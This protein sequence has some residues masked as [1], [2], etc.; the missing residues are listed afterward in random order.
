M[1]SIILA[2]V[3]AAPVSAVAATP[4]Y[5]NPLSTMHH[6]RQ[7]MVYLTF[8]NNT[9]QDR[10][11]RI[12]NNQYMMRPITM[13]HMFV[14]VG[15]VIREYSDQNTK[16]NGQELMQVSASDAHKSVVLK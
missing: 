1:R 14:P 15:S 11:V 7:Q 13:L 4:T 3:L 5:T 10:E 16:V 2:L 9:L 8:V 6:Q 12:G